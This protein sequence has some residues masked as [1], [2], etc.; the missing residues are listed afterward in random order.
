MPMAKDI[1]EKKK[2]GK[3]IIKK[4][5]SKPVKKKVGGAT[6]KKVVPKK[7]KHV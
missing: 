6:K 4:K 5:I 3:K 1:L 7:H 2:K